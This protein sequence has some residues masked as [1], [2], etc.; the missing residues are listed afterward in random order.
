MVHTIE[1]DLDSFVSLDNPENV[2]NLS[3]TIDDSK[4]HVVCFDPLNEFGIGDLNKDVDMKATLQILT[5][6]SRRTN[7]MR[8]ILA[9]HHAIT[10]RSGASK[11]IGYDRSSFAR[12]SKALHSWARGQINIAPVDAN[13]NDRLIFACGKCSNGKEFPP[14]AVRLDTESMIYECDPDVDIK[15]WE[16]EMSG[17]K[18]NEALITPEKVADLCCGPKT[19]SELVKLIMDESGCSKPTAYRHVFAT[20]KAKKLTFNKELAT[21]NKR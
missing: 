6:I 12:N 16:A 21:Y 10:G 8:G 4:A 9:L 7:P 1:N 15:Q 2:A 5:R 14:F 18:S 13:N 19:R 20:I 11:A 17:Q 3:E